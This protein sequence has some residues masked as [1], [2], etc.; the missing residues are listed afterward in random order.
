MPRQFIFIAM[1]CVV[2][3][4]LGGAAL[5]RAFPGPAASPAAPATT[6]GNY[7]PP[8]QVP[9]SAAAAAGAAAPQLGAT[10][11]ALLGLQLLKVMPAPDF[12]LTDQHGRTTSLSEF[13]GKVVVLSFFDSACDDICP[14]LESEL[15]QAAADLGPAA[16]RVA[17]LT[18]NTDPLAW[19][20]GRAGP[21]ESGELGG[22]ATWHFLTGP[23]SRLDA[24]W[25][26][27]GVAVDVQT[28]TRTVSHSQAMYF[29]DASGRV[30]CRATPFADE[31]GPGKFSL[32][33]ATEDR[34]GAAVAAQVRLLLGGRQ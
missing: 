30:R 2:L 25:T 3:L 6:G 17:F 24:V 20:P 21:A 4:G 14:V 31:T 16:N 29:I 1:A 27:Y 7:L 10:L 33:A 19:G 23:L 32:A 34:W 12:S 11:A 9:A 13:R 18:V 28:A 22:L 15:A 5:D 8:F 26:A